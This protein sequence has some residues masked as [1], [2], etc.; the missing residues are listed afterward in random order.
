MAYALCIS[1]LYNPHIFLEIEKFID[2]LK[3]Y[4]FTDGYW[5]HIRYEEN[6]L[7]TP[8]YDGRFLDLEEMDLL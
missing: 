2:W 3:S 5:G 8:I 4:V 1:S 7:P 6:N